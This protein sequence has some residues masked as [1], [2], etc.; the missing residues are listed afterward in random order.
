MLISSFELDNRTFITPLSN[1]CLE[2]GLQC[3]KAY[4]FVQYSPQKCFNLYEESVV[5]ARGEGDENP[6][7]ELW[8]PNGYH[9]MNIRSW[10][11]PG[12]QSLISE[13]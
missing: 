1:F 3:T 6:Y 10:I 13:R 2:L 9:I 12:I 11:D 8:I 4:R 7:Q 5:D